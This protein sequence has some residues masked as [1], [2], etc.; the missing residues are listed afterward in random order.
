MTP[1]NGSVRM[2]VAFEELA[3]ADRERLEFIIVDGILKQY[4]H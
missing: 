2:G 3:D 1:Q 4:G